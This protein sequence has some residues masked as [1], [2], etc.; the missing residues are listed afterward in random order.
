MGGPFHR[1]GRCANT[2]RCSLFAA[3]T[4]YLPQYPGM[5]RP[6][7]LNIPHSPVRPQFSGSSDSGSPKYSMVPPPQEAVKGTT[8]QLWDGPRAGLS[9]LRDPQTQY[10]PS[11]MYQPGDKP[12]RKTRQKEIRQYFVSYAT[13]RLSSLRSRSGQALNA[14]QRSE[15]SALRRRRTSHLQPGSFAFGSGGQTLTAGSFP[16]AVPLAYRTPFLRM[17]LA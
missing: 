6:K 2:C 13:R 8:I 12:R 14:A 3:A 11:F 16:Q 15:G 5:K 4:G 10:L 9:A 7:L 17:T 1:S